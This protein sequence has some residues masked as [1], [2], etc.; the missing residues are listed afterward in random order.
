MLLLVFIIAETFQPFLYSWRRTNQLFLAA[1]GI[2]AAPSWQAQVLKFQR[3]FFPSFRWK[4]WCSS[5]VALRFG[6]WSYPGC[7]CL[8]LLYPKRLISLLHLAATSTFVG[9]PPPHPSPFAFWCLWI[10]SQPA[11]VPSSANIPSTGSRLCLNVTPKLAVANNSLCLRNVGGGGGREE[12]TSEKC[13]G[14]TGQSPLCSWE[15]ICT[16]YQEASKAR[17]LWPHYSD[18][19]WCDWRCCAALISSTLSPRYTK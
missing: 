14:G 4:K 13:W 10:V 12:N 11:T 15:L 18:R 1:T 6:V 16:H 19:M 9:I 5:A 8:F 17:G 3:A 2:E 7:A